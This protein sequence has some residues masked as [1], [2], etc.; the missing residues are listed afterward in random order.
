MM[1]FIQATNENLSRTLAE[2]N[3]EKGTA[4]TTKDQYLGN[5][6]IFDVSVHQPKEK[7]Q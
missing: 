5:N 6:S 2:E 7:N 3:L 1:K 4:S